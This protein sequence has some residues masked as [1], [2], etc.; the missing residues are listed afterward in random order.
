VVIAL[1]RI[2]FLYVM[3]L[4]RFSHISVIVSCSLTGNS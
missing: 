1:N 2:Q 4:R 3:R